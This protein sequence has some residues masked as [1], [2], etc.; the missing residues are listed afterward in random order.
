MRLKAPAKRG[1]SLLEILA[2][3]AVV[4]I[5]GT[6][7]VPVFQSSRNGARRSECVSNLR[8]ISMGLFAYAGDHE[9]QLPAP[10]KGGWSGGSQ[11]D[12]MWGFKIWPYIYGSDAD[13]Q[14]PANSLTMGTPTYSV[15]LKNVF[16]CPET[17][18]QAIS[19]PNAAQPS[20]AKFSYGLNCNPIGSLWTEVG[21]AISLLAIGKPSQTAMVL[22]S[23]YPALDNDAY[24]NYWGMIPHSKGCNA[25]FYDGH[26]EQLAFENMPASPTDVFWSGR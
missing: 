8:Q 10:I 2:T 12:N 18:I 17:R 13:F 7:M 14:Y 23:S 11:Q 21:Q 5:L 26:I 19:V 1:I 6:I 25:L 9:N 20:P 22:E 24:F 3:M 16:R 4:A 15:C